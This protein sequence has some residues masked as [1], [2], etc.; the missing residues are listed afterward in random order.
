MKVIFALLLIIFL[1]FSGYHLSFRNFKLPLFARHLYLTG[2]EFLFLGLLLGPQYVNLIDSKAQDGL[3]PLAALVLG[4]IG[5]LYGFQF[6]IKK[7]RRFPLEYAAAAN[8]QGVITLFLVLFGAYFT[9]PYF[10]AIPPSQKT[11]V[12]LT[13]AAGAACT[14]QTGLAF[15]STDFLGRR[16]EFI[17]FLR[18]V[19]GIDGF[20]ALVVFGFAYV[21]RPSAL[22]ESSIWWSLPQAA[23]VSL[24]VC[25][26]LFILFTLFLKKF[27]TDNELILIVIGRVILISGTASSLNFSPL[28]ANFFVG[29]G[30]VNFSREKERIY[31]ILI[32]I[33]KPC[34]LLLMVFL[35][36][37][38]QL[39]T[40]WILFLAAGYWLWRCM[41]KILGGFAIT[42]VVMNLKK[43]PATLGLGLL[44][45]GGLALAILLD[46]AQSFPFKISG[47]VI[48]LALLTIILSDL[49][50]PHCLKILLQRSRR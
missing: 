30:L 31:K 38:W 48:S 39:D 28:L 40:I 26:G 23:L 33:E 17:R 27:L 37:R 3:A 14:A 29:F 2:I 15:M 44:D 16:H 1:A 11:I 42:R 20:I 32:T 24:S 4:W 43:Y 50:S 13:L 47:Q 34:Y 12:A 7:L 45:Q 5:L 19:S 18:Y 8:L 22:T 49:A 41:G 9:L 46:F 35:G 10:L 21:F 36:V 6:E 25:V